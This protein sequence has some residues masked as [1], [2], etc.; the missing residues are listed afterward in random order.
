[1]VEDLGIDGILI[2]QSSK[3]RVYETNSD[4]VA[5]EIAKSLLEYMED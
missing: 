3:G 5:D 1:M 2:W 4:G